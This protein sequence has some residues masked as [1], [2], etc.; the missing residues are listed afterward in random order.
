MLAAAWIAFAALAVLAIAVL[1]AKD[2]EP[3]ESLICPDCAGHV[4]EHKCPTCRR[5]F[6]ERWPG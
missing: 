1:A 4:Y 2:R 6:R 3:D 5:I